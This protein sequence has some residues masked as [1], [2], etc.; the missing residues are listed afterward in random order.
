MSYID[1]QQ[2]DLE[3]CIK[4]GGLK[5]NMNQSGDG[6]GQRE[7]TTSNHDGW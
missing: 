5:M 4:G 6:S 2:W 3:E 7:F 1:D